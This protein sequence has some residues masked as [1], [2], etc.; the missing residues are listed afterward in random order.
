MLEI[1]NLHVTVDGKQ[2]L[3]GLELS[4]GKGEVHAIM[5]P[6]GS[7]KS[8]LSNVLM[9][10]PGYEVTGGTATLDGL[11]LLS[12]TTWERAQAGLYLAMQYPTEV[13]G[14]SVVNF[15]RTAYQAVKSEQVSALAFRKHMKEQMDRLGIEDAM[16]NRY[17]NQGFS[18]GEKK[19]NEVL[20]LAVLE[21]E[22][23]DAPIV[24]FCARGK[25]S[26]YA[27]LTSPQTMGLMLIGVLCGLIVGITPGIGGRLSI[28]L[29]IDSLFASTPGKV[30]MDVYLTPDALPQALA[31]LLQ[32]AGQFD[33]AQ[34]TQP[35]G[36][37]PVPWPLPRFM[38]AMRGQQPGKQA[39]LATT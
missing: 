28:A 33:A 32:D 24:T 29:A 5:G 38:H 36:Y 16:V 19:R 1:K 6:N 26:L 12:L 4:I 14:V 39:A 25:R 17:V 37:R 7:G 22:E 9:G 23:L 15:L 27:M 20:Q 10:K 18:G 30:K 31:A 11:D 35:R 2:I 13:P 34:R 3:N 8:T 21:P